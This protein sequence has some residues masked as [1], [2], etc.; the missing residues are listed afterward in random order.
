[1]QRYTEEQKL[2]IIDEYQAA[3][4]AGDGGGAAVAKKHG[5]HAAQI[6]QW[7]RRRGAKPAARVYDRT[8]AAPPVQ[9]FASAV[10]KLISYHR[11]QI[12]R[13]EAMSKGYAA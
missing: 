12:E 2:Q 6:I 1:M 11:Q 7:A 3:V 10:A 8:G 5:I 13:L 9:E 4:S